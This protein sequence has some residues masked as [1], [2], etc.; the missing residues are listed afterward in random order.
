MPAGRVYAQNVAVIA[1]ATISS[2]VTEPM[3]IGPAS[4]TPRPPISL[5]PKRGPPK[6][7]S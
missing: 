5:N 2:R 6:G 7:P 1:C 4:A 3:R